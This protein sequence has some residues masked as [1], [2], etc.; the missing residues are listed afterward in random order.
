[1][2]ESCGGEAQAKV[3]TDKLEAYAEG[4]VGGGW[5]WVSAF[6]WWIVYPPNRVYSLRRGSKCHGRSRGPTWDAQS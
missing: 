1:M 4:I 6:L 3:L 2:P 5:L